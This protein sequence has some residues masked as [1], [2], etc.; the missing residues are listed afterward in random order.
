MAR[1]GKSG[2]IIYEEEEGRLGARVEYKRCCPNSRQALVSVRRSVYSVSAK[3]K[4]LQALS[5]LGSGR[6]EGRG[7]FWPHESMR[8]MR[9][10]GSELVKKSKY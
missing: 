7:M 6:C 8:R 4:R 5:S 9:G 10:C 1:E 2:V 3:Y